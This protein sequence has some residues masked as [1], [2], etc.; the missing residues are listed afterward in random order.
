MIL[1]CSWGERGAEG[2]QE[3]G[4]VVGCESM[5]DLDRG[6][7]PHGRGSGTL[8]RKNVIRGCLLLTL[9]RVCLYLIV[10]AV[11]AT[12]LRRRSV[13]FLG[14]EKCFDERFLST[15]IPHSR[16]HPDLRSIVRGEIKLNQEY[17]FSIQLTCPTT[18]ICPA[19]VSTMD[20]NGTPIITESCF[21]ISA[22]SC[23]KVK[24]R[25]RS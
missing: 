7:L 24:P 15:I 14:R 9:I 4:W 25:S 2:G 10:F 16:H 18:N 17:F 11:A 22:K 6:G 13:V 20:G 12:R 19:M 3:I 8:V 21:I 5:L 1:D 23:R